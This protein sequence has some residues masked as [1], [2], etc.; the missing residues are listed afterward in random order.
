MIKID[1]EDIKSNH[2]LFLKAYKDAVNV[3]L[4][5]EGFMRKTFPKLAE[6]ANRTY[7]YEVRI[8]KSISEMLAGDFEPAR[9]ITVTKPMQGPWSPI[10][11]G[12]ATD[13]VYLRAGY[14][15]GNS[16]L[17]SDQRLD[18]A[19]IHMIL[20]GSTGQGKSVTLNSIIY[21]LCSEYA[22]WEVSLALCDAKI[23]E[24]KAYA[25][26]TPLPH[27]RSIAAT[28]DSDYLVSV[29]QSVLD[30]MNKLQSV[31]ALAGA[32][33]ISEFREKTGLCFPQHII[34]IDEFQT[35]F[36]NAKKRKNEIA[37]ILNKIIRL[38]RNAGYHLILASQ[39]LGSDITPEMISNIQVRAAMGCLT[40]NVSEK[41][42]GNDGAVA[43]V[44]KKGHMLYNTNPESHNKADNVHVRVPY[45]PKKMMHELAFGIIGKGKE[46]GFTEPI[47][48]YDETAQILEKDYR[49]FLQ[50]FRQTSNRLLLG[51]PSYVMEGDEQVVSIDF[52]GDDIENL[53]VL[54]NNSNNFQRYFKMLKTN[55]DLY[56]NSV[57]SLLVCLDKMY[58]KWGAAQ[59]KG[60]KFRDDKRDFNNSCL[61]LSFDLVTRRKL[62]L[63]I[64]N[65]VFTPDFNTEIVPDGFYDVF[66]K[67]SEYDTA[68]TRGRYRVAMGLIFNDP[69]FKES[70]CVSSKGN[71]GQQEDWAR[72]EVHTIIKSY[73]SYGCSNSRISKSNFQ[74]IFVWV[75]GIDKMLGLVRDP[76]VA[77]KNRMKK[78]LQDSTD[79]EIRYVLFTSTTEDLEEIVISAIRWVICDNVATRELNRIKANE[80]YPEQVGPVLGVLYSKGAT[81]PCRKFKKMTLD[82]ELLI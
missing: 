77:N 52:T 62:M 61:R 34:I 80:D 7:P 8:P 74:K 73:F 1:D 54:T 75:L 50:Q 31:F 70:Y 39:E 30:E 53:C 32:Q 22:P 72:R 48:F 4:T 58:D 47:S 12:D 79:V 25:L 6:K 81:P 76:K 41:I 71:A 44:G 20:G 49:G 60:L 13:G 33:K 67:G 57:Q 51:E 36:M 11:F 23:V 28:G 45:M 9:I 27:I 68:T 43:Y 69:N 29:L 21:G 2:A 3:P 15:D 37:E 16:S 10:W 55:L 82:G 17:V 5:Q 66:E 24:F 35:M 19:T 26:E 64:D 42:L 46:F 65:I 56:D 38:G 59:L 40:G 78:M 63:E 18:D 14:V